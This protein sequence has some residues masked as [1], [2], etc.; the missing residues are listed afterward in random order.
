LKTRISREELVAI[1]DEAIRL[2]EN[3]D[4]DAMTMPWSNL[5]DNGTDRDPSSSSSSG[6]PAI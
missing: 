1:L 4:E 5:S 6:S 3:V 2:A